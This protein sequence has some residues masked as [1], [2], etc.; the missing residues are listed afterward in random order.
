MNKYLRFFNLRGGVP[1]KEALFVSIAGSVIIL[2]LWQLVC[3]LGLVSVNILPA[4]TKVIWAAI[5]LLFADTLIEDV[6]YSLKINMLGYVE[7]VALAIPI[8]MAIGMFP[9]FREMFKKYVDAVRFLPITALTGIFIYWFGIGDNMKVQFLAFGI[10]VYLIPVVINKVYAV[11]ETYVQMLRTLGATDKQIIWKVF[12]PSVLSEIFDDIRVLVAISWT[13]II[14]VEML[15]RTHGV[16][17]LIYTSVRQS[18]IDKVFALLFII[19]FIG[20]IQ[21]VLF[22]FLDTLLFPHKYKA[23]KAKNA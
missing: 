10:F 23:E 4:P 5:E 3:S 20:F 12:I 21:D 16:G 17:S 9:L 8:G 22:K 15:N 6:T 7:A 18:R 1:H 19:I 14:I 2:I 13:Y 11:N